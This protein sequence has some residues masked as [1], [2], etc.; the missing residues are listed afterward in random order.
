MADIFISYKRE[1]IVL[2]KTLA[3]ML[4][5]FGW[6]VWWDHDIPAGKDYDQI[7][8]EQLASAKC[9]IVLWSALSIN[10][11]NVKDEAN[12][13]LKRNVL[14]PVLIGRVSPPLGFRMIQ[15]ISWNENN[16]VQE[17]ELNE[18]LKQSKRLI[19]DPPQGKV[20]QQGKSHSKKQDQEFIS[21]EVKTEASVKYASDDRSVHPQIKKN[22]SL[23]KSILIWAIVGGAFIIG[24]IF[25]LNA[26]KSSQND[27]AVFTPVDSSKAKDYFEIG[28]N[29]VDNNK[30]IEGGIKNFDKAIEIDSNYAEAYFGRGTAYNIEGLNNKAIS[31]FQKCLEL[32]D[33]WAYKN[34]AWANFDMGDYSDAI[35]NF[36]LY[37]DYYSKEAEGYAGASMSY[38]ISGDMIN[39]K[40]KYLRAIDLDK[41]YKGEF[42]ALESDVNF[43][44]RQ[45]RTL[46]NTYNTIFKK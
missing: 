23:F 38:F 14:I 37:N 45:L 25:F 21:P 2:A 1:D 28:E 44:E 9:I 27:N 19:G 36:N 6:T 7:I 17:D 3:N 22:N 16:Q 39:A 5:E 30:N 31:D 43:N 46:K 4:S 26:K 41:R 20:Q 42:E 34:L 10:S 29:L 33:K 40:E 12:E 13:A 24:L 8:E 18:L 11:R 15:S 32:G 35:K